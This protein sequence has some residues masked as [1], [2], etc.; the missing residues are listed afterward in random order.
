MRRSP[1]AAA[2][3]AVLLFQSTVRGA[4]LLQ[5]GPR[6]A[7]APDRDPAGAAG[8][9]LDVPYLPQ[10][11][12]LCGGAAAAMVLRYWGETRVLPTDFEPLLDRARDGIPAAALAADVGRR[13]WESLPFQSAPGEG[14]ERLRA[15]VDAGRPIIALV[16]VG[17]S[18]YHYVVVV[19]VTGG[20][21]VVHDPARAPFRVLSRE[22]FDDAWAG[23]GRWA[24]LVLPRATTAG[25]SASL[26]RVATQPDRRQPGP[27]PLRPR[28]AAAA[29]PGSA[30]EPLVDAMVA[31]AS[32]GDLS[33][34]ARGLE[35]AVGLCPDAAAP[36]RE[37]ASV[38]VLQSQ[39][40]EAAALAGRAAR[41]DPSDGPGWD[42]LATSQFLD[43]RPLDALA[44][45]NRIGRPSV[46]DIR[47][48]GA[49]RIRQPVVA[50]ALG[51]A[52]RTLLTP[53]AFGRAARR[54]EALPATTRTALRFQPG[55]D[56]R[57]SIEAAV[58]E[59]S[60]LP[61]GLAAVAAIGRAAVGREAWLDVA[62][63]TGSGELWSA[64]WRWWDRRPRASFRLAL[65]A[66]GSV[67]GV[68]T[69]DGLWERAAYARPGAPAGA[70]APDPSSDVASTARRSAGLHLEDWASGRVHWR[71]GVALDRWRPGA[72]GRAD[73]AID[74]RL[75][76]DRVAV[77]G[78]LA[79]W[80][81]ASAPEF[82][83]AAVTLAA[84]T[85]VRA[86][87]AGWRVEAGLAQVSAAAPLDVWE[88]A[89]VG[90]ARAPLLRGHPLLDAGVVTG[91]AFGRGLA[92]GTL[93]YRQPVLSALGGTLVAAAFA[94]TARAW[95]RAAGGPAWQ[96]DA[97]IGLRLVLPGGAGE[98][99]ADAARGLRDRGHALSVGWSRSWPSPSLG[100]SDP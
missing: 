29:P 10:T 32:G 1:G 99:R 8:R 93:E 92:H 66:P 24:L 25:R 5:E 65:P 79:G 87:D 77:G 70:A 69:I 96:S 48:T 20:A 98:L 82:A 89:G 54:L 16:Q 4:P 13:G 56:G 62:S 26:A 53:A 76:G 60:R 12:D 7:A 35:A 97:G 22:E 61:Q 100:A 50:D 58:V 14:L 31:R 27:P 2:V 51:L 72:Y 37:L 59:R 86:S 41:L 64:S 6:S 73:L 83:R 30:C 67:P 21:V 3:I 38:R 36:W 80:A 88:G 40:A 17:P 47:V 78:A 39:W 71:A 28:D 63:P 34:A 43:G 94:D 49:R 74:V 33:G 23:A 81:A 57:A 84:R 90:L 18:R 85:S 68:L 75:A 52:P 42:L 9:L 46:D 15:H 45:W 95:R 91:P 44:S 19:A 55:D 11:E